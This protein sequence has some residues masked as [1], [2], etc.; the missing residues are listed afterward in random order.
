MSVPSMRCP[1]WRA[2]TSRRGIQLLDPLQDALE[3]L[4]DE[5]LGL[6]LDVGELRRHDL[7]PLQVGLAELQQPLVDDVVVEGLLLL[8]LE[9]LRGLRRKHVLDVPE[10]HVVVLHVEGRADE[11]LRAELAGQLER[12]PHGLVGVGGPVDADDPPA[13]R[14]ADRCAR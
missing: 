3:G 4:P 8:E 5:D 13:A 9:D 11:E 12:H 1:P 10:D 14:G 2:I 7:G 6:D